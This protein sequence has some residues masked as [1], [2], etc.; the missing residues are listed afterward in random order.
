MPN[1]KAQRRSSSRPLERLVQPFL[2]LSEKVHKNCRCML[3][4]S[5]MVTCRLDRLG[6]KLASMFAMQLD[7]FF[8]DHE[9]D[10]AQEC[11]VVDFLE[12]TPTEIPFFD[13]T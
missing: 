12:F 4:T 3:G 9:G 10:V 6:H 2:Q 11:E 13:T 5:Q 8:A 1:E 7:D